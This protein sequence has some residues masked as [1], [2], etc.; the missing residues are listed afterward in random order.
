MARL[1]ML[2]IDQR[3]AQIGINQS[4]AT[5]RI[6]SNR[7]RMRVTQGS[8]DMQI[9][10]EMPR[11]RINRARLNAEMGLSNPSDFSRQR[12]EDG[13]E[14]ARRGTQRAV[15]TG[16]FLG[17]VRDLTN[18]V[19]RLARMRTMQAI[20]ENTSF[21]LGHMPRSMPE[22]QWDNNQMRVNWSNATLIIDWEGDHMPTIQVDSPHSV[23]VYLS[24]RPYFRI[25]VE[26]AMQGMSRHVDTRG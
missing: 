3:S 5:L 10:N 15:E 17:N 4:P 14:G 16:N 9:D 2:T 22:F 26:D 7:L 21:E 20:R 23:E 6:N 24:A 12:V 8:P 11:F 25:R 19:P 13:R 1:P 18:G